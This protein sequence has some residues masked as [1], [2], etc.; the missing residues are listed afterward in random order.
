MKGKL[1]DCFEKLIPMLHHII[2]QLYKKQSIPCIVTIIKNITNLLHIASKK[3][4][5]ELADE[6]KRSFTL[7]HQMCYSLY[8]KELQILIKNQNKQTDITSNVDLRINSLIILAFSNW[9]E[10]KFIEHLSNF[11]LNES[12]ILMKSCTYN[13]QVLSESL[14]NLLKNLY[15][16]IDLELKNEKPV[17]VKSLLIF[18]WKLGHM[19]TNFCMFNRLHSELITFLDF[20]PINLK[21]K[22]ECLKKGADLLKETASICGLIIQNKCTCKGK[23]LELNGYVKL[24]LTYYASYSTGN[25]ADVSRLFDILNSWKLQLKDGNQ[26][27]GCFVNVLLEMVLFLSEELI[28]VH[29]TER[30]KQM[31]VMLSFVRGLMMQIQMHLFPDSK[32]TLQCY[33]N[34]EIRLVFILFLKHNSLNK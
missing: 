29:Q 17:L 23:N 4:E 30:L 24:V 16:L 18:T 28:K 3:K 25:T 7:I 11:I 14:Q 34:E 2:K 13:E 12:V 19:Y 27:C 10:N 21:T 33:T 1:E 5:A 31:L 22:F 9:N 8:F 26:L 6:S 32:N 20:V 15:R